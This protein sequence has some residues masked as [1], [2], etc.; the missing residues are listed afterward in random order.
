[1][2][3]NA[4]AILASYLERNPELRVEWEETHKLQNDPRVTR[5]GK[6]LRKTSLDEFPQLFNVIKG[7]LSLV[8]P[9]PIVYNEVEKYE[10][11][12]NLYKK[13]RPGITGLWQISGRSTTSYDERVDLD[14]YY[15][16]NW[17]IWFDIYILAM[18]PQAVFSGH[19]AC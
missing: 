8:G 1:M 7:D 19:G 12:F 6:I 11:A 9:R 14:T 10:D 15:I 17:S 5:L 13:V 16:R 18:T 3:Q 4:D 2:V